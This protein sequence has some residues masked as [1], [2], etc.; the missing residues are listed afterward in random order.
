MGRV[1]RERKCCKSGARRSALGWLILWGWSGGF[2][3]CCGK[4]IS[5][6]RAIVGAVLWMAGCSYPEI[7]EHMH[8]EHTT[9]RGWIQRVQESPDL[10]AKARALAAHLGVDS[11]RCPTPT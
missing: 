11:R 1:L 3:V 10:A 8:R 2:D 6:Q 4:L 5:E 7:G 9:C